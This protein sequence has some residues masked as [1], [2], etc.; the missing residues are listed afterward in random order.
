MSVV[1]QKQYD[2]YPYA[3]YQS[4]W[5]G[6]AEVY[7]HQYYGDDI[8]FNKVQRTVQVCHSGAMGLKSDLHVQSEDNDQNL[9]LISE[10]PLY[11]VL[12]VLLIVQWLITIVGLVVSAYNFNKLTTRMSKYD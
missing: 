11:Y 8:P 6:D 12:N 4:D 5:I 2:C 9:P 7:F 10:K 3:K 1:D